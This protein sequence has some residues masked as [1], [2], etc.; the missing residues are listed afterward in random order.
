MKSFRVYNLNG[1]I[2]A[3]PMGFNLTAFLTSILW[4]AA[5]S[6]WGKAFVLFLGASVFVAG[7]YLGI[8]LDFKILSLVA[9][10]GLAVLPVWAGLQGQFWL[11]KSLE[12]KGYKLMARLASENAA[13]ALETAQ[14]I[15]SKTNQIKQAVAKNN[16]PQ[17][18]VSFGKDFREIRD[19]SAS[20]P[21][22]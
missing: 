17:E 10:L 7:I 18:K 8:F 15:K 2:K 4:A 14:Q 1:S 21:G 11:C 16:A 6:L 13:K 19:S 3:V 9:L 22:R 12:K 5:N 20:S